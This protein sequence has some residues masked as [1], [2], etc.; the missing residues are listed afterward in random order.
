MIRYLSGDEPATLS[1]RRAGVASS[2][3]HHG[4]ILQ[5]VFWHGDGLSRGLVTL[6]C[7]MYA[8]EATFTPAD[9]DHDAGLTVWPSWKTKARRAAELTLARAQLPVQGHLALSGDVPPCRGFGSSTSD[10]LAAIGAVTDAFSGTLPAAD[11]ARLAVQ[12]ETA[13]DSLMFLSTAVLFAHREG[14]VIEDFG[15]P[16]PPVRVL[17][18]G[19]RPEAGDRGIDTLALPPTRYTTD[20]INQFARLREVLREAVLTKDVEL[21]GGVATASTRINQRHLPI[22]ALRRILAIVEETGGVGLQTAHSG[23]IAGILFDRDDPGI[24]TRIERAQQML[25]DIGVLDQ[26]KFTTDD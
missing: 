7:A 14:V 22:P 1:N 23:D 12:A 26:W 24:D 16:L 6:P 8:V 17:G 5:G 21:L 9:R 18:F 3:V 25:S 10:V 4:E 11:L 15:H 13:S 2:P 20:E 19:C